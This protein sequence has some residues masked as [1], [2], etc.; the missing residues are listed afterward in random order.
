MT[1]KAENR[2]LELFKNTGFLAIGTFSSKILVFL[3]IPLYTNVLTTAE[4]GL[5]DILITSVQLVIPFFSLNVTDGV[6]RFVLEND[7][8]VSQVFRITLKFILLSLI[9]AILILIINQISGC[10]AALNEYG[11]Y[12]LAY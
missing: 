3:M 10:S 1:G 8:N 5:Y 2:Y 11:L 4:Y 12:V 6:L 7:N 9:P